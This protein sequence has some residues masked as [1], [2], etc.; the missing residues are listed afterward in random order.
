MSSDTSS[1]LGLQPAA[2][3]AAHFSPSTQSSPSTCA[4]GEPSGNSSI[5]HARRSASSNV[6]N[7]LALT[8]L[9]KA[10][11]A[12]IYASGISTGDASITTT[13]VPSWKQFDTLMI[14]RHRYIAVHP[15]DNRTLG[16]IA[17][18]EPYPQWSCLYDDEAATVQADA[19]GER[20]G[21]SAEIQVMVAEAERG[22]GVGTFLVKSVLESLRADSRYSRVQAS[23]FEGNDA[24]RSLLEK[25]GFE[26]VLERTGAARMLDGPAKGEW[27]DLMTVEYELPP[28]HEATTQQQLSNSTDASTAIDTTVDPLSLLKRPRL[29]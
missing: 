17:C 10:A 23:F 15:R 18:F 26:R 25:C 16:W 29:E 3:A 9:R 27:R 4:N 1:Q 12:R 22:K 11:W 28:W 20:Q 8:E 2:A 19:N 6:A 7:L 13:R 24:A 14:R 21:A 5:L